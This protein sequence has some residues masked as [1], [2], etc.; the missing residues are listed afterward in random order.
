MV[1]NN[2]FRCVRKIGVKP[3]KFEREYNQLCNALT[4]YLKTIKYDNLKQNS[5]AFHLIKSVKD[6]S[7]LIVDFNYTRTVENILLSLGI[8]TTD[9]PACVHKMH[10][11]IESN[12]VFGIDDKSLPF[13]ESLP[14]DEHIFLTKSYPQHYN[15]IN[16]SKVA[17]NCEKIHFFGHSL[18]KTDHM[19]FKNLFV[20]LAGN[21]KTKKDIDFYFYGQSS[22]QSL[23]IQLR[24]LTNRSTSRL[25][26]N[27]NFKIINTE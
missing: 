10:G 20:D 21:T 22:Y 18:G 17:R 14:Y 7:F 16:L 12:I 23:F 4:Q 8:E 3:H 25:R 27:N 1:N 19:Y 13:D 6:K 5:L 26:Q 2:L 24:H 15:P 11:S 9:L